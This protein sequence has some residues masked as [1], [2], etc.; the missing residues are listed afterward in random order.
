MKMR[1]IKLLIF[2]VLTGPLA[3]GCERGYYEGREHRRD[4]RRHHH[5]DDHHNDDHRDHDDHDNH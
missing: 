3:T 5:D 1:L 4:E 2:V